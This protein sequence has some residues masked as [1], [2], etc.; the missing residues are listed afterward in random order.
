MSENLTRDLT[1]YLPPFIAEYREIAAVLDSEN[2]EFNDLG[3]QSADVLD[4][5]FIESANEYGISRYEK[6]LGIT[7]FA[8]DTLEDRKFRVLTKYNETTPYTLRSLDEMLKNICGENGYI[9]ELIADEYTVKVQIALKV[10]KQAEIVGEALGRIL[11]CNMLYSVELLFNTW[12]LVKN[13]NWGTLG[14]C[15]WQDVKEEVLP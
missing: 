3:G 7:F 5:M 1:K 6:M 13:Y 12:K 15:R 14:V 9:L 4:N 2:I 11:P 10:K 8:N